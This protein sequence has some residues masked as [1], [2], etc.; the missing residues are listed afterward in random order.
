MK[1]TN[2]AGSMAGLTTS[3]VARILGVST[4]TIVCW[5]DAGMLNPT[6]GA[7]GWRYFSQ[8]EVERFAKER[9]RKQRQGLR[10]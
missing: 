3:S 9:A 7:S 10:G 2:I 8:D 6:R 5:S 4:R 1:I